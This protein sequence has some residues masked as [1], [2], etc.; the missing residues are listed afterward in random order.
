M[1]VLLFKELVLESKGKNLKVYIQAKLE[2]DFD[3]KPINA[4]ETFR[5]PVK[6]NSSESQIYDTVTHFVD[7]S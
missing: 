6:T 5:I 4:D 7:L 1:D 2:I 3:K